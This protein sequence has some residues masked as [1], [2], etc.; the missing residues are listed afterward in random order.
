MVTGSQVVSA[1]PNPPLDPML[2]ETQLAVD[3]DP[4]APHPHPPGPAQDGGSGGHAPSTAGAGTTW[5]R[6]VLTGGDVMTDA[7]D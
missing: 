6:E 2:R 1:T 4:R 7:L 5:P 3:A